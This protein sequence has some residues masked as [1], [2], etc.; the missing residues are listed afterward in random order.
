MKYDP[1]KHKR[2]SIRLKGYDYAQ[3]GSYFV[4]ICIKN[5]ECL[6]GTIQDGDVN[7][8][9]Y[10]Q[11]VQTCWRDLPNHYPCVELDAF[12]IM[13]NHIHG[14]IS[15]IDHDLVDQTQSE[16]SSA[17]SFAGTKRHGLPEMVRGFKTFSAKRVNVMRKVKAV[18]FWQRN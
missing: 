13:P 12:V 5:R 4:T 7:L 10:D 11:V 8:S 3:V 9:A 17:I 6:L 1:Y 14:I 18:P 15:L 16:S 2:R